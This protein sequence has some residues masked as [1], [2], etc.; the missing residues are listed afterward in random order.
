[1]KQVYILIYILISLANIALCFN[2]LHFRCTNDTASTSDVSILTDRLH[3]T[4]DPKMLQQYILNYLPY[5]WPSFLHTK[6]DEHV[7]P[8]LLQTKVKAINFE[9]TWILYQTITMPNAGVSKLLYNYTSIFLFCQ[10]KVKFEC[11]KLKGIANTN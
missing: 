10:E 9:G 6:P 3:P 4:E 7:Q 1:M 2:S 8:I 5:L 11:F